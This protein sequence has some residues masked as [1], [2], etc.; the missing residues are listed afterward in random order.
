MVSINLP[1]E[2]KAH[3]DEIARQE[4][5]DVT[6][7]IENMIAQYIPR[8]AKKPVDWSLIL[9][10][11]DP[12]ITDMSTSVRETLDKYYQEKYGKPD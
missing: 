1:E 4:N 11:G 8:S 12:S 3:L 5:R 7:V 6:E 10:I 2:V 9:G